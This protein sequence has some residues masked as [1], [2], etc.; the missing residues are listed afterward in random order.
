[1]SSQS[2]TQIQKEESSAKKLLHIATQETE[3]RLVDARSMHSKKVEDS[4]CVKKEEL[5]KGLDK[6]KKDIGTT[7]KTLIQ[8]YEAQVK[9]LEDVYKNKG[10]ELEVSCGKNFFKFISS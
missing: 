6:A 7:Y 2:F 5:E 9:Q 3:Q 4:L 8:G 10:K 1:M